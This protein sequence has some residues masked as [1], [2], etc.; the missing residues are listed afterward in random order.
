[1]AAR[2]NRMHQE[3]VRAKIK[4]SCILKA[5]QEHLDGKR[6][7]SKTQVASA[8]ILLDKSMSN[9]PNI[10]E[11]MGKDGAPLELAWPLSKSSLDQQ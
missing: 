5:L 1:M 4:T 10:T 6:Q 2:L 3:S 9:A 7:L 11:L 8:K